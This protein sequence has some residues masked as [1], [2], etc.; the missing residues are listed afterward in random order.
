MKEIIK[1]NKMII[2]VSLFV[3]LLIPSS[4]LAFNLPFDLAMPDL[5]KLYK[6]LIDYNTHGAFKFLRCMGPNFA[7]QCSKPILNCLHHDEPINCIEH[8]ECCLNN[9][10]TVTCIHHLKSSTIYDKLFHVPIVKDR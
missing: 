9:K 5:H 8:L 10:A 2:G 6:P 4:T 7:H 3:L 1:S